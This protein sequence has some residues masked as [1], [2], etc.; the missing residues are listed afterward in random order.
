MFAPGMDCSFFLFAA[1]LPALPGS[2]RV[3]IKQ[4]KA[5]MLGKRGD[6]DRRYCVALLMGLLLFPGC[7]TEP[8]WLAP[9]HGRILFHG[10]PLQSGTIVFTPDAARGGDGPMA[11]A[12]IQPDGSYVLRTANA[13]GATPG[14]HRVTVVSFDN[15]AVPA[16]YRD[17]EQSCLSFEVRP[18]QDNTININLE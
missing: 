14:W 2:K 1:I 10:Q 5:G 4:H 7:E 15:A 6:M 12:T 18:G 17:P 3:A 9:V 13:L 11:Q 8:N 16:R